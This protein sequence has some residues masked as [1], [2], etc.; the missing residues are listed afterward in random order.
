MSRITKIVSLNASPEKVIG[1]ISNVKNH[2]AFISAL[3]SVDHLTGDAT[4]V[5][6]GWDWTFMMGGV[7]LTGKAETASSIAGKE[8]SFKTI[9]GIE[10]HFTYSVEPEGSG[11]RLTMDIE[12]AVPNNVLAKALDSA[13]IER[14]NEKEADQAIENLKTILGS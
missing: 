5:G 1:Y 4:Q 7:E 9:G 11:S 14:L 6:T 2:P 3:K 8:Y 13:I 10:S 12:Y